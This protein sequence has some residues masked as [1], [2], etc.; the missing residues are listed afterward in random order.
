MLVSVASSTTAARC[1]A[2]RAHVPQSEHVKVVGT[3]NYAAA[4]PA[5]RAVVHH[6]SSGT[7]DYRVNGVSG[8]K[9]SSWPL[10]LSSA[11]SVGPVSDDQTDPPPLLNGGRRIAGYLSVRFQLAAAM[12]TITSY[13]WLKLPFRLCCANGPAYSPMTRPAYFLLAQE[14]LG[15]NTWPRLEDFTSAKHFD[16]KGS[17]CALKKA[18]NR[19]A[20]RSNFRFSKN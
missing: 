7:R 3:M 11:L 8:R 12:D 4:C 6:G 18:P 2:L 1:A 16:L 15:K 5:C 20:D 9:D 10:A 14:D 17:W 19:C 13:T